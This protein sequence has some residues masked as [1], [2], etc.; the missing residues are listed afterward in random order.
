MEH[1][2]MAP[3]IRV[4]LIT[5]LLAALTG[6]WYWRWSRD[7]TTRLMEELRAMNE[8]MR[9]RLAAREA[10]IDRLTRSRRLAHIEVRGQVAGP[11]GEVAETEVLFIELDDAGSELDRQAFTIPGDVLFVDAW[12]VKFPPLD[13]ASGHPLFGRSLVLLRR[14]YSDRMAPRDGFA[15]DTPGAIPPGYAAADPG[16]LEQRLWD[17]FWRIASDRALADAIGVR[18]AQG[19]AVYKPVRTGQWYELVVDA[20]G[21]MSLTPMPPDDDA[22]ST[23]SRV[24]DQP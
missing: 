21:G 18:V 6:T 23:L 20:A 10:M 15:I 12:T 9:Q 1:S 8:D 24:D 11:T 16:R 19:E 13:V 22:G 2:P 3:L 14:I 17:D 4:I 7:E 5:S